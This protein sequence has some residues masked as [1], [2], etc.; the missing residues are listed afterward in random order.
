MSLLESATLM[1]RYSFN[2]GTASDSVGGASWAGSIGSAASISGGQL[3]LPGGV[4]T[5][6]FMQVPAGILGSPAPAVV[7]IELWVTTANSGND[8]FF[9]TRIF[10]FGDHIVSSNTGSLLFAKNVNNGG[11]VLVSVDL[12]AYMYSTPYLGISKTFMGQTNLHVAIVLYNGG[13][14]YVYFNGVLNATTATSGF[15]L[16]DGSSGE[17]NYIGYSTDG[18]SPGFAGSVNEF[19]VWNG[20]LSPSTIAAHFSTG[21]DQKLGAYCKPYIWILV[22]LIILFNVS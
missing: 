3:Q 13:Y 6:S 20:A 22:L 4:G 5:N 7:T 2:D 16:P 9:F 14:G 15:Y 12:N 17:I 10:Q 11:F 8:G 19:R 1:H 21:P 18:A